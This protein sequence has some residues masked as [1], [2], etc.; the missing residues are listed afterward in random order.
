[1]GQAKQLIDKISDECNLDCFE[2]FSQKLIACLE[3]TYSGAAEGCA[4]NYKVQL[5]SQFHVKRLTTLCD[6]WRQFLDSLKF[7]VDPLVQQFVNQELYSSI[8]KSRCGCHRTIVGK[9]ASMS[10][11][12]ENIVR[13]AAGFVPF[14]L[15]KRYE[16]NVS[17]SSAFF[18]EC[19]SGMA[20]TGEESS[21]LEYTR[22]WIS[23]VN[24]G[25][26]FEI[27]DTAFSLFREIELAMRD[28]LGSIL[29]SSTVERDQKDRLVQL[30]ANDNDVQFYWSLLSIDIDSEDNAALLL[31]EIVKLW[32]TIRG[33]SIAGQWLEIYKGNKQ[34]TTKK[35]KSLRKTLQRGR[36]LKSSSKASSTTPVKSKKRNSIIR[37]MFKSGNTSV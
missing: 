5:W 1:M 26:L 2:E 18:V 7:D 16:R 37:K 34:V 23:K 36:I 32:L 29:K 24:R 35:S 22:D 31:K 28:R 6:M 15:L 11:E 17:T 9:S 12:E 27:N 20:V 25:G 30:V 13:Y 21:F 3:R 10:I 8:I 19:L 4:S 14:A 33:F